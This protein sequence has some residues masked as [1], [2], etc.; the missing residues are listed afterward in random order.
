MPIKTTEGHKRPISPSITGEYT[1]ELNFEK[2][3]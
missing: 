2:R 3:A 1:F